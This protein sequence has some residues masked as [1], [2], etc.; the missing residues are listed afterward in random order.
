[1][2]VDER[3]MLD[4]ILSR[5]DAHKALVEW[6]PNARSQYASSRNYDIGKNT[7]SRLSSFI[8]SGLLSEEDIIQCANDI[9]IPSKNN[10]FIEEIFWRI[11]FRGYLENRPSIWN[12]YISDLKKLDN[13]KNKLD[14]V[15]AVSAKTGIECFDDWTIQLND[16][17]YLHNHTRMWYAS[18]WVFT[19]NLPWQL[20]ADFFLRKLIDAD[21]ASNTLSWRWVAGLHTSK[22]P[23]VARPDNIFKYTK[24]YRP[25][26]NQLNLCPDA[27]VEELVH[28]PKPLV[29]M[30]HDKKS[31]NAILL[32]DNFF[33][34][35]QISS[36]NCKEIFVVESPI[37][38]SFRIARI[39]D[40]VQPQIVNHISKKFNIK[41]TYISQNEIAELSNNSI[42][43]NRPRVGLWKDSIHNP[44]QS[45]QN[46]SSIHFITP[47]ID[48]LSWPLCKGG[49]FKL[50]VG[51]PK[52]INKLIGQVELAF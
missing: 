4:H 6:I 42:I 28:E 39:W 31:A 20:G 11:Y 24:K 18:I 43:T 26:D 23:Y 48:K 46:N 16:T 9:G 41:P 13:H 51:I 52:I 38:P 7:T 2:V 40:F 14:Y 29:N 36:I 35:H 15:N 25:S 1:M 44:I 32:H 5:E 47:S 27:I 8:S 21:E 34:I 30:D 50:K 22:K 17:G 12:S 37:D 10:K 33:P 49:Y 19:L 3:S 45:L